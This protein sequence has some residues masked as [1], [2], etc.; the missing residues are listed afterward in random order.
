M[1]NLFDYGKPEPEK[2]RKIDP[3]RNPSIV[4]DSAN[5][6]LRCCIDCQIL[7]KA[8]D[9]HTARMVKAGILKEGE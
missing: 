6:V 5:Q 2:P 8:Q 4:I 7:K 3:T 1:P 9:A